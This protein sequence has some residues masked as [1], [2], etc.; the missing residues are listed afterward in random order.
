MSSTPKC[1][2]K[3]VLILLR[4]GIE[5]QKS[6]NILINKHFIE[7][8]GLGFVETEL[9]RYKINWEKDRQKVQWQ[10]G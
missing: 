5:I 4:N 1:E 8:H 9:L 10:Q 6:F 3:Q 2:Q 7:G